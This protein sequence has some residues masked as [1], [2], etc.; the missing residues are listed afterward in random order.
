[1]R[2]IENIKEADKQKM[3]PDS[4]IGFRVTSLKYFIDM[5]V[6][7]KSFMLETDAFSKGEIFIEM[8]LPSSVEKYLYTRMPLQG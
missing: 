1:M 4:E 5:R 2:V 6:S 7:T 8:M 3:I